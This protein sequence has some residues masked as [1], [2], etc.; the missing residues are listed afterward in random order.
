[1]FSKCVRK[2]TNNFKTS[3]YSVDF[4][5]AG[6]VGGTKE[7]VSWTPSAGA[8]RP[9]AGGEMHIGSITLQVVPGDLI[10]ERTDAIVNGTNNNLDFSMGIVS[11]FW[12]GF[13]NSWLNK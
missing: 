12:K 9:S 5:G 8:N 1:M 13:L 4:E 11:Y 2:L 3:P 6:A 10:K 7:Q